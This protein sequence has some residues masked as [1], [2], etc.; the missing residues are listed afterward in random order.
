[1]IRISDTH[2]KFILFTIVAGFI[3]WAVYRWGP[4]LPISGIEDGIVYFFGILAV[5]IILFLLTYSVRK[6]VARGM[7][8]RLDNWLLAHIYLGLLG[9]FMVALH[10]EFRFGWNLSTVGVIFFVLVIATG[11]VGRYFYAVLPSSISSDQSDILFHVGQ[12]TKQIKDLLNEK[13]RAF[14]KI[15]GSELD[16]PSPLSAKPDYWEELL[17]KVEIIP[18]EER[19]E[20]KKAVILL[21]EKAQLEAESV[22]QV[23]YKPLFSSW[24]AVHMIVTIGLIIIIPFHVLDDTFRVFR[25]TAS[26]FQGAQQ[27]RQCH[28]RQYDEWIGSMHAYAQVSPVFVA[29]N[30]RVKNMGTG[31]FCVRCHTPIGTAIGEKGI[32]PNDERAPISLMG[33]QCDVCHRIDKNHGIVSGKFPLSP[34]RT[35]YGP[36][37]SGHDGDKKAVRNVFH[38]S[39]QGDFLKTSEFCGSCHDVVDPKDLRIEEAFTEWKESIYAKKGITC[40]DCHMRVLPGKAD[41]KKVMGPAAM[42]FGVNLR[43]RPLSDHSFIGPDNH[44]ID[45]FPYPDS[46]EETAR[47]QRNYLEKKK[48]LLQNCATVEII[49]PDVVSPSS[50][51]DVEVKITNKGAGHGIPTGFTAERQVWIEIIVKDADG[52]VLFVSGDLDGNKDLRNHHSHAVKSG[53]VPLDERL[54]NLQS[55]FVRGGANGTVEEVLLPTLAFDIIKHN[56]MPNESKSGFYP[57][58]LPPDAKG[59]I[60]VDVRLRYRNLP[61]YLLDFLGVGELKDRLVIVDMATDSKRIFLETPKTALNE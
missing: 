22:G 53:E 28:Q 14:Q 35:K 42:M 17:S 47:I 2:K 29:F 40:Q 12:V 9:L 55:Q 30:D 59:P 3:F 56:I 15:I 19:E 54:V 24:L 46:P 38:K 60:T 52:K 23:K 50:K 4:S 58:A 48:Y 25:P 11:I 8:G 5:L 20:F 57:I 13:S 45:S 49:A 61:P 34:G 7:P 33:V 36:F 32:T 39:R 31:P 27:C 44:L 6:R 16:T 1:M 18:E 43:D 10:A 37:G 26:D 51:F 41:Q 21:K